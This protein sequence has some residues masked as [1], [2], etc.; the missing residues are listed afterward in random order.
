MEPNT[1]T[2]FQGDQVLVT[3]SLC[4]VQK[5]KWNLIVK[6]KQG[7]TRTELDGRLLLD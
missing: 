1:D 5:V 4:T 7:N 3:P 6:D 2:I